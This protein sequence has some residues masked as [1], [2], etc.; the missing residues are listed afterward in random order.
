MK[1]F[2]EFFDIAVDK[3][4]LE[5]IFYNFFI[6]EAKAGKFHKIMKAPG[7]ICVVINKF[8]NAHGI[9]EG[10]SYFINLSTYL[11]K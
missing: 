7:I 10:V 9:E 6:H 4:Y 11:L 8:V 1:F 5:E 3:N 2:D